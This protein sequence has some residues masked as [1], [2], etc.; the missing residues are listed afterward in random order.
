MKAILFT[1]FSV[2]LV[3]GCG[4]IEKKSNSRYTD[5]KKANENK[6][7][8]HYIKPFQSEGPLGGIDR[9]GTPNKD[10]SDPLGQKIHYNS[11]EVDP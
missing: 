5:Q 11:S 3:V 7:K 2:L 8:V 6:G 10:D 9:D 4:E 1:L